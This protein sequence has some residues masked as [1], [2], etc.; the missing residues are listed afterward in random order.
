MHVLVLQHEW[1]DGP[2]YLGD[3]LNQRGATLNIVRLDQNATM[4]DLAPYDMLL[5]MVG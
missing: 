2:G 3:A 4:P 5:V 1:N